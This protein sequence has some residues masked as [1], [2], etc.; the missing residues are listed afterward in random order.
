MGQDMRRSI[1]LGF[2]LLLTFDTG[3]Q[4][5]M[6]LAADRIGEMDLG[7]WLARVVEEPLIHLVLLCY[8]GAFLT[9]VSLLKYAPVG[10]AY[11]AAHGHIVSVLAISMLFLGERLTLIQGAGVLAIIAGVAILAVTETRP[12]S[13]SAARILN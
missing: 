9:Y 10:P 7:A 6:K 3:G 11:A 1:L 13:A 8:L 12:E 4:V 5:G 2:L